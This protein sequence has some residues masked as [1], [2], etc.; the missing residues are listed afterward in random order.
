MSNFLH[1]NV[2]GMNSKSQLGITAS[3]VGL[4]NSLI[5]FY[6]VCVFMHFISFLFENI[7]I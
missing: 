5:F 1:A 4:N 7:F 3:D 2:S 6:N